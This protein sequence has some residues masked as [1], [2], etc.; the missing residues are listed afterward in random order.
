[1]L[2]RANVLQWIL[3][4]GL[5]SDELVLN[6]LDLARFHGS[7]ECDLI[8]VGLIKESNQS[9]INLLRT[10][11]IQ[12]GVIKVVC[13]EDAIN[14][15]RELEISQSPTL[16]SNAFKRFLDLVVPEVLF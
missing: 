7:F 15:L 9:I 12:P 1:M 8:I 16:Y 6:L 4:K 10:S 11:S 13:Y 3:S 5:L 2:G 14:Q